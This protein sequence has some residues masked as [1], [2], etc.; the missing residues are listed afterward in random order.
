M[1]INPFVKNATTK[2]YAFNLEP[3]ATIRVYESGSDNKGIV[4]AGESNTYKYSVNLEQYDQNKTRTASG[5][6]E[7]IRTYA[8]DGIDNDPKV[9]KLV[10]IVDRNGI[11]S[12]PDSDEYGNS[13]YY[14]GGSIA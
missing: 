9:R 6:Y 3:S 10:F 4:V 11:I 14:T 13:V 2:T 1:D 5:K 8:S 7:I 12:E